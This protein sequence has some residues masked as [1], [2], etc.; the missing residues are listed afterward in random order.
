MYVCHTNVYRVSD[1]YLHYY[2]VSYVYSHTPHARVTKY[3]CICCQLLMHSHIYIY[4]HTYVSHS[5]Y[6][7][8]NLCHTIL[9]HKPFRI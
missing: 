6:S 3:L 5:A 4:I 9:T 2:M 7:D 8:T 1:S